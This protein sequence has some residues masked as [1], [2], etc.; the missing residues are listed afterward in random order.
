[1]YVNGIHHYVFS[2]PIEDNVWRTMPSGR[3]CST[4]E[5]QA[6]HDFWMA[7]EARKKGESSAM[8][9]MFPEST[10]HNTYRKR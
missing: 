9:S 10:S 2:H 3:M 7:Y 5:L 8:A 6:L 1:V 4:E